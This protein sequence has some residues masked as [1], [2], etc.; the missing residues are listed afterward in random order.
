MRPFEYASAKTKQQA[1]ALLNADA[2][3][4]AGGSD[5]LAL[6][7]DNVV[8]PKRLVN[9]KEIPDLHAVKNVKGETVI[10]SLKTLG[11][12]A[13]IPGWDKRFPALHE[14][15]N[16]A[17]SPQ[18]RNV[19]T[20]GGN[21]C[22]RPRCWY[23][24]NGLGLLPKDTNGES[25]VLKGDN[26]YHAIL[27]NDGPAYFVSPSTITPALIA[28][29]ARVRLLGP[30]G[31]REVELEKFYRIPTAEGVREHDL[32]PNEIVTEVVIP[33]A[34]GVKSGYYEV[35]QKEVFDWP[36]AVAAVALTMNGDT[37]KSARVVMGHVAPIPWVSKEAADA[38]VGKQLNEQTAMAAANASVAQ[39]KSLGRNKYKITLAKVAVKR[40]LLNAAKGGA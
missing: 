9:I 12:L 17:A 23:F 28:Y 6:M 33:A 35:R 11:D 31:A 32:A 38:L 1:V 2:A 4:L 24:R 15:L 16:E 21:L 20:L 30:N 3:V 34:E 13:E 37:V 40:A 29:G 22:Q 25:L 5:L 19:A 27:G 39:A 26:R 7:K 36:L 10:G 8:T 18:I 14:A